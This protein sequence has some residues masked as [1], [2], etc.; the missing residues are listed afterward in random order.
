V[1]RRYG[2][3]Q[4]CLR[5]ANSTSTIVQPQPAGRLVDHTRLEV[6]VGSRGTRR[7][8]S[9]Q[10]LSLPFLFIVFLLASSLFPHFLFPSFPSLSRHGGKQRATAHTCTPPLLPPPHSSSHLT[11]ALPTS[12]N[13]HHP[14]PLLPP[15]PPPLLGH[16]PPEPHLWPHLRR[17]RWSR[18]SRPRRQR[19]QHALHR[20]TSRRSRRG[21]RWV[22]LLVQGKRW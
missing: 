21:R 17:P 4:T 11:H 20:P 22:R 1:S 9:N 14:F 19:V 15:P 18:R 8:Q 10:S 6:R 3:A 16:A 7:V 12:F 13:A 2:P 5:E